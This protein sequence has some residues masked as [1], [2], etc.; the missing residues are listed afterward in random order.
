[1]IKLS[2]QGKGNGEKIENETITSTSES[3]FTDPFIHFRGTVCC[4]KP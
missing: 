2:Q 4:P 1:M 3:C